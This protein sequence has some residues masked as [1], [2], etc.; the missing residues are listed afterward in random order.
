MYKYWHLKLLLLFYLSMLLYSWYQYKKW[1]LVYIDWATWRITKRSW[2]CVANLREKLFLCFW[3]MWEHS[4]TSLHIQIYH[5][6]SCSNF[7]L[8]VERFLELDYPEKYGK[9]S[10]NYVLKLIIYAFSFCQWRDIL[11][12][13][14]HGSLEAN[15]QHD[16]KNLNFSHIFTHIKGGTSYALYRFGVFNEGGPQLYI[17]DVPQNNNAT[18]C[19]PK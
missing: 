10:E 17:P 11:T 6:H 14:P 18:R 5:F 19:P 4:V 9:K 15:W 13:S 2:E 1:N 8:P 3:I 12:T 7:H 16:I